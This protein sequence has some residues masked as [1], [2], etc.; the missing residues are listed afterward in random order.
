MTLSHAIRTCF[1]KYGDFSG[2]AGRPEFWWFYLFG[3]LVQIFMAVVTLALVGG[4]GGAGSIES[5]NAMGLPFIVWIL[6]WG[7][8][9][10][11]LA[12]P[13]L[14]VGSRRLHD[15]D[16]SGWLQVLLLVPCASVALLILWCLPGTQGINR[17]DA[18]A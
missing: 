6:V 18:K 16:K 15:S 11:A 1:R 2:R 4:F 12:I 3:S 8:S 5:Q 14:A 9:I 7:L 17:F 10:I 13:Q